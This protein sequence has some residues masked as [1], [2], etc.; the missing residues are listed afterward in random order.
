MLPALRKACGANLGQTQRQETVSRSNKQNKRADMPSSSQGRKPYRCGYWSLLRRARLFQL[1]QTCRQP[2]IKAINPLKMTNCGYKRCGSI[3]FWRHATGLL[4]F[5]LPT[6]GPVSVYTQGSVLPFL[7][8]TFSGPLCYVQARQAR[9]N[10]HRAAASSITV[11]EPSALESE[12]HRRSG[13]P[14]PSS[15]VTW[16]HRPQ[17][18]N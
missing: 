5:L 15:P 2:Q 4:L 13:S 16:P 3:F 9:S 10:A 1:A 14:C 17:P 18:C 7:S 12:G 8:A 6:A 11:L